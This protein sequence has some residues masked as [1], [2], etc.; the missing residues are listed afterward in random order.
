MSVVLGWVISMACI[1][2]EKKPVF[3]TYNIIFNLLYIFSFS[4]SF[5]ISLL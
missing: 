4:L 1:H 3:P 5:M 2:I